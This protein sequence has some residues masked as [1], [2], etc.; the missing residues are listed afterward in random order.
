[1]TTTTVPPGTTPG[2]LS[3]A[4][5]DPGP[6]GPGGLRR[7]WR[8]LTSMRTALLLL[9]TLA[10]V[11]IPG[12]LFPQRGPA[13]AR[14]QQYLADHTTLGPLLDKIGMFDVFAS[15]WFAAVYLL[16]FVSLVGCLVPRI[17]VHA[18]GLRSVP[19]ATPRHLERMRVHAV[20]A[21]GATPE[22]VHA[23]A[24]RQLHRGLPGL[25]R[26]QVREI[27][28]DRA[29]LP[30]VSAER[31]RLRETGNLLFHVSLVALLVA[32]AL[33]GLFGYQGT[34]IVVQ[35]Q[36]F[37]NSRSGYD[38]LRPGRLID[39]SSLAPFTT[40]LEKMV[41]RFRDNGQ[42]EM[43]RATLKITDA[44]GG[45]KTAVVEPNHPATVNGTRVYLS[46]N[47]YAPQVTV[48]DATGAI[49]FNGPVPFLP[50]D[51]TYVSTGVIKVPDVT[52]A[53]DGIA[54]Q[55]GFRG[56]FLPTAVTSDSGLL[57]S[58][59][60]NLDNPTLNL[61]GF[62]GNLGLD[63]TAQSVFQLDMN[64]L[65]LVGTGQKATDGTPLTKLE[66]AK[67]SL[68]AMQP[69]DTW[70]VPGGGSVTFDGVVPWANLSV[71]KDPGK[72]VALL[73][74]ILIVAGLT[75]SLRVRRRRLWVRAVTV[76]GS[77]TGSDENDA[78]SAA[79]VVTL[80]GLARSDSDE[81]GETVDDLA[82]RIAEATGGHVVRTAVQPE[83]VMTP[84]SPH[85][86]MQHLDRTE[87]ETT[88]GR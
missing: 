2:D 48:R 83:P 35:G 78:G 33:G 80:A 77:L 4:P 53:K 23:L 28:S 29:G 18:A 52:P 14:V 55:L 7:A 40:T 45:T 34:V 16:L 26:W 68:R 86:E 21:T 36:T 31:G 8:R 88:D 79:T 66:A 43:F 56:T 71:T 11:A 87:G 5:V 67:I 81:I 47:G 72:P 54:N 41:A 1:M 32:L 17:R 64:G 37:A 57:R 15:P 24:R 69:G 85:L 62:R 73:A 70:N 60:P 3:S 13:P 74:A 59:S 51:G 12:S 20:V 58:V 61:V 63:G 50:T 25:G 27:G 39:D 30:S 49:A 6:G 65:Q 75:L 38:T 76:D 22:Q 9:F 84:D 19:P 46:G 10:V 44:Q 42:P 82:R